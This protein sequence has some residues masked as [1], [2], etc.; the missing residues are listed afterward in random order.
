MELATIEEAKLTFHR[1]S[2]LRIERISPSP[3]T[4][5]CPAGVNAKA[6]VSLIAEGRFAQALQ[7][8]RENCPL[9]GVC[10]RVCNHPCEA[11]CRRNDV[12]GPVSIRA[13]KRFVAD[14]GLTLPAPDPLPAPWRP[15]RIA[16]AGGGPAGL[17]C[18]HDLAKLGFRVTL[19]ESESQLGGMLRYGIPD[20][21]LPPDI[22]D[23]EI[24]QMLGAPIEVKTGTELGRDIGLEDLLGNGHTAVFIAV[25]A[26]KSRR[27]GLD[28]EGEIQ[29]I[30]DAL[31]V[32]KRVNEGDR[33]PLGERVLVV[34]GGSSAIDA[35]RAALRL[36]SKSADIVYRRSKEEMPAVEEEI[37]AAEAEGVGIRFLTAP[38]GLKVENGR[39]VALECLE[40][41]L[42]EPDASGRR[43]PI[44]VAGSNFTLRADAVISSIGQEPYL[45]F[46]GSRYDNAVDTG[47]RIITA[48][49]TGLTRMTGI[50]AGGDVVTGPATVI[51]AIAMG[52]RAAKSIRRMVEE[53]PAALEGS[54]AGPPPKWEL[55]LP[56]PPPEKRD[57]LH[58]PERPITE[59][60]DFEEVEHNF[61]EEDAVREASRCLRCGPCS[62]CHTCVSTCARR[63]VLIRDVP[64]N[65]DLP[66][67]D[68]LLRTPREGMPAEAREKEASAVLAIESSNGNG[69]PALPVTVGLVKSRV[70]EMLCRGCGRCVDICSFDAPSLFIGPDGEPIA[71]IDP[72]ECRGCGLC[73]SVCQTGA[74]EIE[75]FS[76]NWILNRASGVAGDRSAAESVIITCQRR[77][78]CLTPDS[79]SLGENVEVLRLSCVGQLEAGTIL[80]LVLNGTKKVIVAGC[81]EDRCRFDSGAGI[82]ADQVELAR[83]MLKMCGI[84]TD[85]VRSNWSE[86]REG[87]PLPLDELTTVGEGS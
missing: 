73:V 45:P 37:R 34:G 30:D 24:E 76:K 69:I 43:R 28:G 83:S 15:E 3:C 86:G 44:P 41:R 55:G 72:T 78:G 67:I 36:G 60:D 19:I 77:G 29:G 82:A 2:D 87:D 66:A 14:Y 35:A 32:L 23:G 50:F 8:V 12:D 26:S 81:A 54:Q 27:L 56:D 31:A 61:S 4:L 71:R 40:V 79:E 42:G 65:G 9:P 46:F 38:E 70:D 18:A 47:G 49:E 22:L 11:V 16:V 62:E 6:Y 33:T 80:K 17:T 7:V 63:H 53:G 57:R 52:H 39:V 20:Y 10:G 85:R 64:G 48:P 59:R 74:A 68:L 58:Q 5:A 25:G 75:P 21:R 84:R 51:E 13:L 1:G